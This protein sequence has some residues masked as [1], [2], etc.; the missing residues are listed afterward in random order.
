MGRLNDADGARHGR[1]TRNR[2]TPLE[3]GVLAG[4]A[5]VAI[6]MSTLALSTGCAKASGRADRPAMK[7]PRH[8]ASRE[9]LSDYV[10]VNLTLTMWHHAAANGDFERYFGSMTDDAVFLGTDR[11]ERWVGAEFRDFARPYFDGVEAWTYE[12]VERHV[13]IGPGD[14][15]ATAWAD[16]VLWNEKYGCCRGTAVLVRDDAGPFGWRIAHYSLSFL[17][18][19]ET[20]ASVVDLLRSTTGGR[21]GHG[22]GG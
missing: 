19:N 2:F 14:E 8:F 12:R 20:A 9:V 13:E 18:P 21:S 11:T 3:P 6:I 10:M 16:E 4:A 15:P 17:I 5:L 7:L 22:A 1:V